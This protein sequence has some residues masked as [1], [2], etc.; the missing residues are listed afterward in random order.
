MLGVVSLLNKENLAD[1]ENLPLLEYVEK[2]AR[3]MDDIL[4]VVADKCNAIFMDVEKE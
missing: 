1:P 4:H 2:I 3:E